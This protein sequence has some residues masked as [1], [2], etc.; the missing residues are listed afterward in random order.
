[1]TDHATTQ[2]Q[3]I[4]EQDTYIAEL[5]KQIEYLRR[6][7]KNIP[8]DEL[9]GYWVHSSWHDE[10]VDDNYD[11]CTQMQDAINKWIIGIVQR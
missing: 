10:Y 2:A 5:E 7:V 4:A 8:V 3:R 9:H 6:L 1:M 11:K